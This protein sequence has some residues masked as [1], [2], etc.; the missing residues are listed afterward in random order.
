MPIPALNIK[1]REDKGGKSAHL[2]RKQKKVPGVIYAKGMETR[3]ILVDEREME[4]LLYR[5]GDST[6]LALNLEGEKH[7]GI[8]KD[9]QRSNKKKYMLH[10]DFQ[11]LNENEKFKFS[12]P[13]HVHNKE[14]MEKGEQIVQFQMDEVEIQTLPRYFPEDIFVDL[15]ILKEKDNVTVSDL[16]IFDDENIEILDD[17]ETVIATLVYAAREEEEEETDEEEAAEPELIGEKKEE[18]E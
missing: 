9:I 13:I 5:H 3:S 11:V 15:T 18:E 10:V 2:A 17:P 1:Y 8:I 6:R 16:N 12:L 14:E 4:A 7:L